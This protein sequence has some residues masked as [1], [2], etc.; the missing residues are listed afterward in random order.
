MPEES[1][2]SGLISNNEYSPIREKE[3]ESPRK[4]SYNRQ[5]TWSM[6]EESGK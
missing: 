5:E 1:D 6:V 3:E 2:N 4:K